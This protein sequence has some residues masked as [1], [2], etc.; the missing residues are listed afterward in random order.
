MRVNLEKLNL[1]LAGGSEETSADNHWM[2]VNPKKL[3]LEP[4]DNNWHR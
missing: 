1:E 2:R 3:N 4:P